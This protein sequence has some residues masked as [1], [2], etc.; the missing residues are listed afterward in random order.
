MAD[1]P[2][3]K[4][5]NRVVLV[6]YSAIVALAGIMGYILGL[7]RPDNLT[8][9]LFGFIALPPT[10]LGVAIYGAVTVATGLGIFLGLV[11]YVSERYD[12]E[13]A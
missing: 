10:P 11:M 7:I 8:P 1:A 12:T 4:S 3:T 9:E 13:T 5:G 2:D 6:V